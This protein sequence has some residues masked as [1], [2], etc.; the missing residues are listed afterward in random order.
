MM[1]PISRRNPAWALGLLVALLLAGCTPAPALPTLL[2]TLTPSPVPPTATPSPT[3]PPMPTPTPTPQPT[4]TPAPAPTAA[5][6]RGVPLPVLPAGGMPLPPQAAGIDWSAYRY[7][8]R[9]MQQTPQGAHY[10][11]LLQQH[12]AEWKALQQQDPDLAQRTLMLFKAW[13]VVAQALQRG[14]GD[15]VRLDPALVEATR[16][17][18]DDLAAR[19]SP[20]LAATIRAESAYIPWGGLGGATANAAWVAVMQGPPPTPEPTSPPPG[21]TPVP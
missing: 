18:L 17:Y 9:A 15:L 16:A 20:E 12:Q 7:V 14:Q 11:A 21:A 2:P 8:F 13:E 19:G 10:I 4:E 1:A 6:G 5:S 3:Q